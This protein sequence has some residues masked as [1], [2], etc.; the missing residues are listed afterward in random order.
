MSHNFA[1]E[2]S[3][4]RLLQTV[5]LLE[6][7]ADGDDNGG[8]ARALTAVREAHARVRELREWAR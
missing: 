6:S 3:D 2:L 8:R 5:R 4:M 1:F 7:L